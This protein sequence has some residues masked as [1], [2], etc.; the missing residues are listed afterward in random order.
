ME[1]KCVANGI[2]HVILLLSKI[3]LFF[4]SIII[5]THFSIS[6]KIHYTLWM[7][8]ALHKRQISS[9]RLLVLLLVYRRTNLPFFTCLMYTVLVTG[10]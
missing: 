6:L 5:F 8:S 1:V 9:K 2:L 4:L 10:P 3:K 7:Y